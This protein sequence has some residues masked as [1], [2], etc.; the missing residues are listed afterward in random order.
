MAPPSLGLLL[1]AGLA[2]PFSLGYV[3][4]KT[5]EFVAVMAKNP[6]A[7]IDPATIIVLAGPVA[8]GLAIFLANAATLF[9]AWSMRRLRHRRWALAAAWLSMI[10]FLSPFFYLGIPLGIWALR[11]MRRPDMKQAFA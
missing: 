8:I 6:A 3:I 5:F 11:V 2:A 10:P 1:L 4:L 7:R 9:G